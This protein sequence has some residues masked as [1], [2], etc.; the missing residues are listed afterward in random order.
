MAFKQKPS[1][2]S[3]LLLGEWVPIDALTSSQADYA[4]QSK[5]VYEPLNCLNKWK[6]IVK[7]GCISFLIAVR[8][9]S[10]F[11]YKT[12]YRGVTMLDFTLYGL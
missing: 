10:D 9:V 6:F 12:E 2:A 5:K 11:N 8:F 7:I 3:T 4:K 1:S